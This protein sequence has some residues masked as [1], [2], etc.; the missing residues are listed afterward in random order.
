MHA[1][2]PWFHVIVPMVPSHERKKRFYSCI[3]DIRHC[4]WLPRRRRAADK[5]KVLRVAYPSAESRLDPQ[6]ES[7]TRLAATICDNI[8]DALLQ[9]DYLARPVKL[10][11]RAAAALPEVTADGTHLHDARASPASTSRPI[12]RSRARGASS[13]PRTTSTRIKRL[14]DPKVRAPVA[15]PRRRQDRGRRR[16]RWRTRR[17]TGR[18]DYD[19]PHR[20]LA[21]ARPLHAAHQA[22]R[23]PTTASS[24][25]SRCPRPR[26]V[27]R[28]VVEH[29]GDDFARASRRHRALPCSRSG[30]A[31]RE[32]VLEA[33]PDFREEYFDDARAPT[34]SVDA[35]SLARAR[36]ASAC[37]CIG[38]IEI[39]VIEETQPRWLAFLNDE[40]DYIRA[41]AR[42][43]HRHRACPAA[44]SRPTSRSA[45]SRCTPDE[46]ALDHLHDVQHADD[47]ES[48]GGYTP[49]KV[50]LR[51]AI[52]HG[53]PHRRGDRD[54]RQGPGD[55][56]ADAAAA[57]AC[58]GYDA[59]FREPD[60]RVQPG[61]GE[62]AARHVRL[63]RPRRRRLPRECPTARR[64]CIDHASDAHGSASAQRNELWKRAWTTSASA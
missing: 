23:S 59:G 2:D 43:V 13:P 38:R 33:N 29:Y 52:A 47:P 9:Y 1:D 40:H 30:R 55:R 54:P 14:F 48:V 44:S 18:F 25:S 51:R 26:A 11:P 63:R 35:R 21:G 32:I 41:G 4:P 16:G 60:A 57:R 12:P 34:T 17:R 10:Q 3:G 19:R 20:G 46:I 8:F 37:R 64:S 61:E 24:T 56:G 39:Y 45:A 36:R 53:L 28:E 7:R 62:G 31:A 5:R 27:A 42:G 22:R 15:L 49:E 50:A 58:A 6:A